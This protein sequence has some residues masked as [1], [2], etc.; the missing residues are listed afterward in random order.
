[1]VT[2]YYP[3]RRPLSEY[4]YHLAHGLI[5]SGLGKEL[6]VLSGKYPIQS[7]DGEMRVWN[8]GSIN[9]PLQI[10]RAVKVKRPD[11]VLINTH[12]TNWGGNLANL[13][14][15]MTPILLQRVGFKTTTLVHHLPQT[16]DAKRAGYILTPV[17][18]LGIE[19]ACRAIAN[20]D[21]V[22]FTLQRDLD[23]FQQHYRPRQAVL[24]PHGL[25]G[26]PQ[27][28]PMPVKGNRVLTFGNWGRSKNPEAVIRTFSEQHINGEL[29]VA[30]GSSHTMRGFVEELQRKYASKNITFT[31]YVPEPDIPHLFHSAHLVVL[32]YEE[33][34]GVSGVLHQTCQYGRVPII[35]RLPVFEQMVH[36]LNLTA[37]FYD[38][39]EELGKLVCTL[40]SDKTLLVKG[41]KAN[42][43]AVTELTMDKVGQI[44]WKLLEESHGTTENGDPCDRT[45]QP[46][47]P[48]NTV[49]TARL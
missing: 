4:G 18:H 40:L 20:S 16:I 21:V 43:E 29:V 10:L 31:G 38:T 5:E 49:H 11:G 33:N 32:P 14:G 36:E 19:L 35:K 23:Y 30:G 37:Y 26:K 9:I 7:G 12:F 46:V 41:G 8:Y 3:D 2:N 1:M 44:Y 48:G 17:H 6:V 24:V 13:A 39:E 28:N 45:A 22:C 15:L 34:T 42:L 25:L 47:H 27:W